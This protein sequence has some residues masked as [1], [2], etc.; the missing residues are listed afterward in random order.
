VGSYQVRQLFSVAGCANNYIRLEPGLNKAAPDM[1][2]A[3]SK[4]I[5]KLKDAGIY[6]IAE[7]AEL[8]DKIVN[9]LT[10]EIKN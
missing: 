3:S 5:E 4:N 2:D 6:Y 9:E 10:M 8:L 1:D 7:N